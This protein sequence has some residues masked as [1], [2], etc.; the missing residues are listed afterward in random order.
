MHEVLSLILNTTETGTKV[1]IC[2]SSIW[3]VDTEGSEAQ[4][5]PQQVSKVNA[6]LGCRRLITES[7][8]RCSGWQAFLTNAKQSRPSERL[9][10]KN[11][12]LQARVVHLL[13]TLF[14][15]PQM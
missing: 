3:R 11:C 13:C 15:Y 4:G 6:S 7:R 8:T 14:S 5:H 2:H 1:A 10:Y 12:F 9:L